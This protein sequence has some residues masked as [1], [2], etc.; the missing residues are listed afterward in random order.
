[1]L[2]NDHK[3]DFLIGLLHEAQALKSESLRQKALKMIRDL[4]LSERQDIDEV[5]L[6][7]SQ[8][9]NKNTALILIY[10]V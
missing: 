5:S 10:I 4:A 1:M 6:R 9:R 7:K 3:S 8:V 2:S